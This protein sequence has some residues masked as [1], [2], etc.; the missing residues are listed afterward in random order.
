MNAIPKLFEKILSD[1]LSHQIVSLLSPCQHGFCKSRSTTTN[2]LELTT[3]VN[4]GF[5]KGVQTDVVYTDFSKAFDKVNHEML[6]NKL[7][8]M[9]FSNNAIKWLRSYLSNRTQQVKFRNVTSMDIMVPSGVPQGSHLGPLLFTLFINDLPSII[10]HA[11][12]LMYADDV[13][14]FKDVSNSDHEFLLQSDLD[15]FSQWCSVNLMDLNIAKCKHMTFYRVNKLDTYYYVNGSILEKV[16]NITDL[17]ILLD[18]KI[19]FRDHIA[20]T[21]N[22][23]NGVLGFMK[24]WSKEFSDPY[25][26]K[27]LYTSLVRPILE[28]GSIVWDPYYSVH[29]NS[30]E[31]VQKQFLIFCLRGLGWNSFALPS[32][33]DRL[34]LIKLPTLKSRRVMLSVSFL[35]GIIRG[36]VNSEYLLGKIN[37]NIPTRPTRNFL[38]IKLNYYNSVFANNDPFRRICENFNKLNTIIDISESNNVIKSKIILYLNN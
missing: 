31:S 21:V 8:L 7:S 3:I 18:H 9:G 29:I 11:K 14:I 35:I 25:V 30:I 19:D 4:Y 13:K 24:R 26:T 16:Y 10:T 17:G 34:R 12:I 37:F 5:L 36:D 1:S 2:I 6:L 15:K 38:P 23:A 33:V 22:K 20:L 27:H 28:Y 32:Y